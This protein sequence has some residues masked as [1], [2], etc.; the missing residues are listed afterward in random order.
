MHL[1]AQGRG[2]R[3]KFSPLLGEVAPLRN[4]G[5]FWN[6][7]YV[8]CPGIAAIRVRNPLPPTFVF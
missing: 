7:G 4:P 5:D 3:I 1:E 2:P 8:N 6:T